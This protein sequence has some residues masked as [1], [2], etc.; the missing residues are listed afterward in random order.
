MLALPV[1]SGLP[2][3]KNFISHSTDLLDGSFCAAFADGIA[4]PAALAGGIVLA[5]C[6]LASPVSAGYFA[7]TSKDG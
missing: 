2:M 6:D 4:Q 7:I 1:S 3:L 5:V